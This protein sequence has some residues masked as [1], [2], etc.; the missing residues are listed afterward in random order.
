MRVFLASSSSREALHWEAPSPIAFGLLLPFR[1]SPRHSG[2]ARTY[3]LA[4]HHPKSFRDGPS[5]GFDLLCTLSTQTWRRFSAQVSQNH[6]T[7]SAEGLLE[8]TP[9]MRA[10]L[11]ASLSTN[12][13]ILISQVCS[14]LVDCYDGRQ[15]PRLVDHPRVPADPPPS[16]DDVLWYFAA[17]AMFVVSG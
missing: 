17:E 1:S 11:A 10:A 9:R 16:V 15:D 14:P 4:S 3:P 5:A 12:R 13:M 8:E 2:N 6:P 7:N